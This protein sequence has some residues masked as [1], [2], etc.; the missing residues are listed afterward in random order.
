M[1][2][3]ELAVQAMPL[4][5]EQREQI[6]TQREA[7]LERKR[8]RLNDEP[9]TGPDSPGDMSL[10]EMINAAP[11]GQ[12]V[13]FNLR[14]REDSDDAGYRAAPAD[15]VPVVIASVSGCPEYYHKESTL[16]YWWRKSGHTFP[17]NS[18]VCLFDILH[19]ERLQQEQRQQQQNWDRFQ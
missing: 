18:M 16:S 12:V 10:E 6:E 2:S 14:V 8:R 15:V 3:V 11:I 7:A 1:S 17:W 4:T 9:K 5:E 19:R 13:E